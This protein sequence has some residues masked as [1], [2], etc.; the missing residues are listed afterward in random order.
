MDT[1]S[2]ISALEKEIESLEKKLLAYTRSSKLAQIA[3]WEWDF[4]SNTIH[5]SEEFYRIYGIQPETADK[6]VGNYFN[7]I[8]PDDREMFLEKLRHIQEEKQVPEFEYRVLRPNG[9]V[10]YIKTI[11]E[12]NRNEHGIPASVFSTI[13]DITDE[14]KLSM[15]LIESEEKYRALVETTSTGYLILDE[16]GRVVDANKEYVNMTGRKSLD[17]ILGRTVVEWT[18]PHDKERNVREVEVC[19]RVGYVSGLE[20]DY[21]DTT[22]QIIP[23]EIN[24]KVI[25]TQNGKRILALCRDIT[26]RKQRVEALR[27]NEERF[28]MLFQDIGEGVIIYDSDLRY[29]FWNSYMEMLTGMPASEVIGKSP[30]GLFPH[31]LEYGVD[32]MMKQALKGET[33]TATNMKFTSSVTGKTSRTTG[34]YQPYYGL[35]GE[36]EGVIGIIRDTTALWLVEQQLIESKEKYQVIFDESVASIY[37]FDNKKNFIDS[38]QSGLDLL[39]YTRDELMKMSIPDVDADPVVVLPAH[40]QL[41]SGY[42]LVNYEHRLKKKNGDIITV[43]N[44][45]RSITDENRKVIGILSTLIDITESKQTER[46]LR[47][48]IDKNPMSIQIVDKDGFTLKVNSAHTRLFGSVPPSDWSIFNDFQLNQQGFGEL[49]KRVKSG[50]IVNFPDVHYNAHDFSADVPDVP[51]W[52]RGVAFPLF[53]SGESPKQFVLMHENVSERKKAEEALKTSEERF[54]RLSENMPDILMRWIPNHGLD[55]VNPVIEKILGIKQEELIGNWGSFMSFVHPEDVQTI[56]KTFQDFGKEKKD[57]I[58]IEFRVISKMGGIVWLDVLWKPIW[59]DNG[60][61]AAIEAIARNITERKKLEEHL[62]AE[63]Y[64][65]DMVTQNIGAGIAIISKNYKVIWANDILKNIF[66]DVEGKTCHVVFNQKDVVC[67][68]CGVRRVFEQG[69]EVAVHE[70][71]GKNAHGETI[72]SEI[73]ATPIRESKGG[74]TEALE[75]VIP[76]TDRKRAEEANKSLHNQLLQAQKM[77]AIGTL[78]GGMAHDFNN[79]LAIISGTTEMLLNKMPQD[80]PYSTPLERIQRSTRRAK[81]LTMKL[82]TFARK[83][84]LSARSTN[85]NIIVLDIIDMLKGTISKK[86]RISEILSDDLKNIYVDTNQITQAV[87][88]ICINACDAMP[89]GGEL[90][91]QTSVENVSEK[92]SMQN[93]DESE[94]YCVISIRDTGIGIDPEIIN[95][96]YEPFFTTKD[97]GKGSGLGLSIC[98]GII[99]E[100]NG[101]IRVESK[102][103]QGTTFKIFIP[104][105]ES[106][107]SSNVVKKRSDASHIRQGTIL[108]VDDDKDFVEMMKEFLVNEG[109]DVF[110]CLSG[111]EAI[112]I[113]EKQKDAIDFV[114]LDMMLPEIDGAEIFKALKELN[115]AVKIVICSGYSI[116]G[117]ASELMKNGADAFLQKPFDINEIRDLL[118]KIHKIV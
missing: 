30:L 78:A 17:E 76:I 117:K 14:K 111:R 75:L 29:V 3:S 16:S 112:G 67:T 43:L 64:K 68:N 6:E 47:D 5:R 100:H 18:A 105:Y 8:H 95:K 69:E 85:A 113:Y 42:R 28:R 22:G 60:K 36:I 35:T 71:I 81:D 104:A 73:I 33:F 12:I 19:A 55:Y 79:I 57:T 61:L 15:T 83:E 25:D 98:Y 107:I 32:D 72:W 118:S 103:D 115:P 41:L 102:K 84:K 21:M 86:I 82:L 39:G 44:N 52:I 94:I 51:I 90:V 65:L 77:E 4:R 89:D 49:L 34:V 56:G 99:K 58:N 10:R 46:M 80:A 13:Q 106:E 11:L 53:D 48:I 2:N 91:F 114:V 110:A 45:S 59:Q 93:T 7:L 37:L 26:E 74:V 62:K 50:E 101:F 24:A 9:D 38:N 92:E 23:I 31:L 97:I 108:L 87:L 116:D 96:I 66:G 109:F 63:K 54:R 1:N 70:Q 20:I 88:N 27:K 40:E